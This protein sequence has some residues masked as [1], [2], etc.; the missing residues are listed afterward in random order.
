MGCPIQPFIG[1]HV[2]NFFP[3]CLVCHRENAIE[4]V[5]GM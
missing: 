4:S 2:G 3:L 5:F 1:F